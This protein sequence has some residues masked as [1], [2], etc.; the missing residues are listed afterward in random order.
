MT[1]QHVAASPDGTSI[2]WS[3]VGSGD[4]VVLVHGITESAASFDPVT[5]RLA[6]TNEVITL[7]LRGHGESESADTY[8]LS[9]M[10]GDVAAVIAS[11]GVTRPHVVGHSL[12]GMVATAAGS[13]L[14]FES[15]VNIDQSL[16]L[17]SFKAQL[18]PAEAMLRDPEQYQL[19]VDA[20]FEMMMGDELSA[21]EAARITGLRHADHEVVLGVWELLLTQPEQE[22][23]AIVDA[24]LGGYAGNDVAYLALFGID[25]GDAY[26][27]W[28][29]ARIADS[30][31]EYWPD[32]GHYPHLVDPD[33]FVERV[34]AFW[35]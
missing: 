28:L 15:I 9:S 33:R 30:T 22:I 12:G 3:R 16:R 27:E 26:A 32:L 14:P 35:N 18:M 8:D 34:L 7:D 20:M 4:P 13:M 24:A 2:A 11:S 31:V 5:E 29:A 17:D 6:A 23:A 21:A 10:A 1:H 19:V 25:P